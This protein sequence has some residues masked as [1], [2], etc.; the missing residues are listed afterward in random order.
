MRATAAVFLVPSGRGDGDP[1]KTGE[2]WISA[3]VHG[4]FSLLP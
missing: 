1:E 2:E 3:R 4:G